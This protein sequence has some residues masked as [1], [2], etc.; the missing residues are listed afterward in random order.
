[1][2]KIFLFMMVSLDG[3]Y[4]GKNG[5]ISWHNADNEEFNQFAVQQTSEADMLL[6][7][8][9]TYELMASYWPTEAAKRDDP[10]VAGLMNDLP[11]IVISRTLEKVE[12][13]NT[14]LVKENIA[15][16]I[17][18]LKGQPGKDIAILGSSELTVFLTRQGLVDE[19]RIMVNPVALGDGKSLF[20]GMENKLNLKFIN[21]RIFRSGNVLLYYHPEYKIDQV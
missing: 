18:Q 6:F 12:W 2:R 21:S 8:R 20:K 14:R 9:K 1:M 19:Y 11:K 15:E 16:E 10:T 13:E 7:G 3:F 17:A 4:E 5:D